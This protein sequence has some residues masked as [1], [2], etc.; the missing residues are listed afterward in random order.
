MCCEWQLPNVLGFGLGLVQMVLYGIYRKGSNKTKEE[1]APQ[2][3]LKS[4]VIAT[5]LA[6]VEE[7][8]QAK[9]KINGEQ[10]DG[11]HEEKIAAPATQPECV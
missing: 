11:N 1:K 10:E 8:Q 3:P 6:L 9:A 5:S 2:E 7:Q 4:I